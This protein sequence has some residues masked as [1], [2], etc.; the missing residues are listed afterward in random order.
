MEEQ[1]YVVFPLFLAAFW[2]L[3]RTRLTWLVTACALASLLLSEWA[4]RHYPNANYFLAPP[5]PR[6]GTVRRLDRG[7]GG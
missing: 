7:A 3:G 6:L 1:Y 4:W 2:R 5:H